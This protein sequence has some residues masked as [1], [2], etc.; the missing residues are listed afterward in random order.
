MS[1]K[2]LIVENLLAHDVD[3]Q[4]KYLLILYERQTL[5]EKVNEDTHHNNQQGFTI[6]DA[7]VLTPI[8]ENLRHG[9]AVTPTDRQ[10][11]T[12]RLPKY[13]NQLLPLVE[14]SDL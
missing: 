9:N 4:C 11:L 7:P 12:K 6:A 13:T 14:E 3:F 1:N 10:Q 2:K 5:D 8:A